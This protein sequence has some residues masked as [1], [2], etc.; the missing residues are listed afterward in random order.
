MSRKSLILVALG[1]FALAL[2]V[3][4]FKTGTLVLFL[5]AVVVELW[6]WY[7]VF[8]SRTKQNSKTE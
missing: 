2:Y 1:L 3:A 6:F 7:K 4:G 8:T 5:A